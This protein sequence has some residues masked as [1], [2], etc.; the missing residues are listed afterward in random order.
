MAQ[1]KYAITIYHDG[2]H[3]DV[4]LADKQHYLQEKAFLE[5]LVSRLPPRR[6]RPVPDPL[7][8]FYMLDDAQLDSYIAHRKRTKRSA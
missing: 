1:R 4:A 2:V 6:I 3:W 5:E 8:D 7:T